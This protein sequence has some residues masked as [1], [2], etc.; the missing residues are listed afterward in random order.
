[1]NETTYRRIVS[2]QDRGFAAGLLR[3]VFCVLSLLYGCVIRFRNFLYNCHILPTQTVDVPV[4]CVGN[5]TTGG[6]GKTPL[7]I[8]LCSYLRAKGLR[9]AILTRGYRTEQGQLSDEPALLANACGDVPVIV[10]SDRV[11]GARKA[12]ADHGAQILIMDDGF[13]HR[14]LGRDLDIV[15]ID[16]TCPFGYG[17]ILPAGL[18][19]EPISELARAKAVVVTRCDLAEQSQLESIAQTVKKHA[20]NTVVAQTVHRHT[21]AIG[22]DEQTITMDTLRG[23]HVAAFCGIGNPDAFYDSLTHSGLTVVGTRTFD[24]HHAYI[25]ADMEA[26]LKHAKDNNAAMVLCTQKD[27]NKCLPLI[28]DNSPVI[29]ASLVMELDFAAGYDT[30]TGQLDALLESKGIQVK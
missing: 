4:I 24:D 2:G 17:K 19:R 22:P 1:M 7:V 15:T 23:Q 16:A 28:P 8:W 27:W 26:V 6:T 12:I 9:P 11:A 10:N 29:F 21:H 30:I 18:L 3:A 13:Q 25:A 14:R 20:P 5:I